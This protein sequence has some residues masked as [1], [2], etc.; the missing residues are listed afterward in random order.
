MSIEPGAHGAG[1]PGDGY[2]SVIVGNIRIQ[3]IPAQQQDRGTVLIQNQPLNGGVVIAVF[4]LGI[5]AHGHI[6][7]HAGHTHHGLGSCCFLRRQGI[8]LRRAAAQARFRGRMGWIQPVMAQRLTR[9]FAAYAALLCLFTGCVAP[10]MGMG[11]RSSPCDQE[12]HRHAGHHQAG[13]CQ[14]DPGHGILPL[15]VL[16]V[17]E[18]FPGALLAVCFLNAHGLAKRPANIGRQALQLG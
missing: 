6:I 16:Q 13:G 2:V 4:G 10:D 11:L 1:L 17:I 5:G 3:S 15:F 8:S 7:A 18:Q 14:S 9:C 12:R